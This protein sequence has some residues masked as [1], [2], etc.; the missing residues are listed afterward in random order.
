MRNDKLRGEGSRNLGRDRM[1]NDKLRGKGSPN[2]GRD[3]MRND[4]LRGAPPVVCRLAY[5]A[6]PGWGI[7]PPAV[8]RLAYGHSDIYARRRIFFYG[9]EKKQAPAALGQACER[10]RT[11]IIL[12]GRLYIIHCTR[13]QC[14]THAFAGRT[15][16]QLWHKMAVL[17][18][19]LVHQL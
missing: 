15:L 10:A 16:F 14:A 1:P 4:K 12:M 19:E 5:G 11:P 2:L 9:T 8:C 3:R 7:P 13:A 17:V 18:K 6:C